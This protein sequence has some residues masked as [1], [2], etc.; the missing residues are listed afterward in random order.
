MH[1]ETDNAQHLFPQQRRRWFWATGLALLAIGVSVF[2]MI[3]IGRL[4]PFVRAHRPTLRICRANLQL[5]HGA[6]C[7][8]ALENNKT[9]SAVPTDADLFG[10][11][12]YIREKPT[13]P[14]GGTYTLGSVGTKP[15]C[16]VPGH[17]S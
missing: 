3:P 12:N 2:L 13:C 17:T 4:N 6:K 11:N 1:D 16:T 15:R 7:S 14:S 8:W 9:N 5:I 10:R